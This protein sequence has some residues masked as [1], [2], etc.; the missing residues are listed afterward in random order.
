LAHASRRSKPHAVPRPPFSTIPERRVP[1]VV[2]VAGG[3]ALLEACQEALRYVTAATLE[4]TDV[5]S[6]ATVIARVRP[7]AILL[8]EDVLSFDPAEFEALARDVGGEIVTVLPEFSHDELLSV[9]L[10]RLKAAFSAWDA[11][12]GSFD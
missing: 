12:Q 1:A 8:D 7:F 5:G 11:L 10:P 4:Q 6:A 3:P 9:L 2:L